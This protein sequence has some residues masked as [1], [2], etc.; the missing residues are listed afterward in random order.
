VTRAEGCAIDRTVAC[1]DLF[2]P[3]VAGP[4]I[5]ILATVSGSGTVPDAAI[6]YPSGDGECETCG[7]KGLLARITSRTFHSQV[8]VCDECLDEYRRGDTEVAKMVI[9]RLRPL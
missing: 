4:P 8:R 9:S 7:K 3:V 5:D 1:A 2:G 6:E